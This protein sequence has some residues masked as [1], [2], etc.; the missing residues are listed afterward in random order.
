MSIERDEIYYDKIYSEGKEYSCHY[1][2]S[3]YF[4]L[5]KIVLLLLP[6]GVEI[7]ELG[8]GTGQFAQMCID[9]KKQYSA[10]YDF[11]TEAINR[12]REKSLPCLRK[13][14]RTLNLHDRAGVF[15]ALEV[16]EHTQDYRVIE[17]IGL[18]KEI[19]FTVPDFNDPSH[20]R[21][22]HSVNEVVDRY[23]NV[24]RFYHIQKFQKWF[25]CK[26]KT[27]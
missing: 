15:I 2:Q 5:W 10:G 9:N 24:L 22:F 12:A 13:D 26:A 17:N 23:K 4:E 6:D 20:I 27:I 21:Y 8:C 11:S 7:I 14:I 1:T 19:V 16:F 3:P 18:G 25:V